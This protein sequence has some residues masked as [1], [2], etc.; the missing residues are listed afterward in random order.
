MIR[1]RLFAA[2]AGAALLSAPH[3]TAETVLINVFEIPPGQEKAVLDAWEKARSFLA[4]EPGYVSTE[5]HQSL[6]PDARFQLINI[7]KWESPEAFKRATER[8]RNAAIF[9]EIDGLSFYPAL[10]RVVHSD[11]GEIEEK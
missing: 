11:N 4:K 5:L 1:R 2:L 10:Y 7:A 6:T 9:P 3:A 8:L